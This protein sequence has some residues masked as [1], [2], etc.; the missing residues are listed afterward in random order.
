MELS[1]RVASGLG[2][3]HIF[4]AQTHYQGQFREVLG[5]TAWPGTLNVEVDRKS[6]DLWDSLR[7][8]CGL[9]V[10][11]STPLLD[12]PPVIGIH[13]FERDGRA[14]G[15]ANAI[16]ADLRILDEIEACAVLIPDLTRHT[17]VIEIICPIFLRESYQL[18]D[19]DHVQVII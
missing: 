1:G 18:V 8:L 2:R 16:C 4:M 3:A 9:P 13:G 11:D 10:A 5:S 14:F 7:A 6:V 12:S 19:G 15:G 17:D